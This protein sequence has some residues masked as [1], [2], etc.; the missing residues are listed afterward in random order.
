MKTKHVRQT[1]D[2]IIHRRGLNEMKSGMEILKSFLQKKVHEEILAYFD[3]DKI[4]QK[5]IR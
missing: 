5:Y 1:L 4:L 2:L 3:G